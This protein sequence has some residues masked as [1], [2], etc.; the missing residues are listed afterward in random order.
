MVSP[1]F[2][3]ISQEKISV[4][5]INQ[6]KALIDEGKLKP[7]EPLPPE[8][9]LMDMLSVSRPSLR[10]ALKSLIG[11]GYLEVTAYNRTVVKSLAAGQM[12]DPLSVLVQEDITTAFELIQVRKALESW[13]CYHAAQKITKEEIVKMKEILS[14]MEHHLDDSYFPFPLDKE[15]ADFHFAIAQA[16]HNKVQMHI[17]H[18][19]HEMLKNFIG[20]YYEKI[21]LTVIYEQHKDVVQMLEKHDP[22]GARDSIMKHLNYVESKLMEAVDSS[23]GHDIKMKII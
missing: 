15:D 22:E 23:L 17:M 16:T 5:I 21:S 10:E 11:M 2:K 8:R 4:K 20:K 1:I 18:T 19:V 14:L 3:P 13:N 6:I 7:G 12:L 9:R